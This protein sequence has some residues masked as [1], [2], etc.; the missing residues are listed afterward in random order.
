MFQADSEY[1][2]FRFGNGT[3]FI[4]REDVKELKKREPPRDNLND[5]RKKVSK[6]W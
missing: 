6:I 5:L 4:A 2:E 3:G 1:Y